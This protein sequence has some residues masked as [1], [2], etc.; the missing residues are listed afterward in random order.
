MRHVEFVPFRLTEVA[1]IF[2]IRINDKEQTELQEFLIAFKNTDSISIQKDL[3]QIV[4][5]LVEISNQGSKESFFRLEGK[6]NDRLC[7]IPLYTYNG[8]NRKRGGSLRLY[9]IRLS[10]KLL[11]V[12][13]GGVK[14]TKT[15]E[16]DE[17]LSKHVQT[18]QAIDAELSK[19]E[20]DGKDLQKEIYNL[21]LQIN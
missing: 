5:S 17:N 16:E 11:I 21:T 10:D 14:T 20:R 18:L 12:G 2:S 1:E 6:M 13:N 3:E 4:R 15:Y 7:A 8:N 19:L 9:C